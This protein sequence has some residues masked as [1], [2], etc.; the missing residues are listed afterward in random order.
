MEKLKYKRSASS[1]KNEDIIG[2]IQKPKGVLHPEK[3][4]SWSQMFRPKT[5][6]AHNIGMYV[7]RRQNKFVSNGHAIMDQRFLT[8]HLCLKSNLSNSHL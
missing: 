2:R 4:M 6:R 1:Y 5:A 7:F 8:S 3:A